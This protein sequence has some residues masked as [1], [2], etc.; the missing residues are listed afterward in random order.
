MLGSSNS[1]V[2]AELIA[3]SMQGDGCGGAAGHGME[4]QMRL[5][6]V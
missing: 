3:G 2:D 4:K 6:E 5:V 1:A